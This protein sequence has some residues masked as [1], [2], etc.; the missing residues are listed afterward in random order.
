MYQVAAS[1][2][3][4]NVREKQLL[5]K[6]VDA[7]AKYTQKNTRRQKQ[8][9]PRLWCWK[10][11][12]QAAILTSRAI[13]GT[14]T[15]RHVEHR[16]SPSEGF[17]HF[18]PCSSRALLRSWSVQLLTPLSLSSAVFG[19]LH[20]VWDCFPLFRSN[21]A[22]FIDDDE[23]G[24]VCYFLFFVW[25]AC[26]VIVLSVSRPEVFKPCVEVVVVVARW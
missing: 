17:F 23:R 9:L 20:V 26:H 11:N 5:L 19:L 10:Q 1:G 16:K 21:A 18:R 4:N 24:I 13:I 6:E 25:C 14:H 22:S 8:R 7:F 15:A 12:A 2:I 3:A